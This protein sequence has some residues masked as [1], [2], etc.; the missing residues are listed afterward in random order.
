V[1]GMINWADG[2]LLSRTAARSLRTS[3]QS[4]VL[5]DLLDFFHLP[6]IYSSLNVCSINSLLSARGRAT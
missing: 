3:T 5:P 4:P 6:M 2:C 1:L